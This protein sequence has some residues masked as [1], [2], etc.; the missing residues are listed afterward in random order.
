MQENG[1]LHSENLMSRGKVRRTGSPK[2]KMA[3]LGASGLGVPIG[4]FLNVIRT[5]Y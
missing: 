2:T 4:G 5:S 3:L 1:D